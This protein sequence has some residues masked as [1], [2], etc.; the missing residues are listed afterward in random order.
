MFSGFDTAYVP[1]KGESLRSQRLRSCMFWP[2]TPVSFFCVVRAAQ[3]EA[4][5]IKVKGEENTMDYRAFFNQASIPHMCRCHW[6]QYYDGAL[7]THCGIM[8]RLGKL[9]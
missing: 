8:L 1:N 2:V 9:W 4:Y 5:D 7:I 6:V 3:A